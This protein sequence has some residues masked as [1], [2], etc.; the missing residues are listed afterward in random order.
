MATTTN[1]GWDT[2]DDTD[3]V[4]D[5]AAAI[6][7]LGQSIDTSLVD[8][9]GGTT[10]QVLAK[11][12]NTDMDFIWSAD[13]AGMANP[14]T[15]TG[16][17][18]YSSSGSTPDRLPIGTAGQIL[19]VNSGATAPEWATIAASSANSSFSLLNAGGTALTGATTI[20]VSGITGYEKFLVVVIGGSTGAPADFILRINGDTGTNYVNAGSKINAA[21]SYSTAIVEVT[22]SISATGFTAGQMSSTGSSTVN[23]SSYITGGLTTG[24]KSAI[25]LGAGS[26]SGSNAHAALHTGGIYLGTATI[27]SISVFSNNNNFDA[28]TLYVYGSA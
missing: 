7:T 25:T 21:S 10:G 26:A 28:G 11:N 8:L 16:D 18:I 23:F 9:K 3:L 13:A 12:S 22:G 27:S 1:Y 2:P 17:T 24:G 4:K 5:G 15:T 19:Q 20:T 6:R 14:M